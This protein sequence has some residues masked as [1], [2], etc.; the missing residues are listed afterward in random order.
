MKIYYEGHIIV[1]GTAGLKLFLERNWHVS[2]GE[3]NS[4]YLKS[5]NVLFHRM[6]LGLKSTDP[7]VD[8]IN[9]N[10]LDNRIKNLRL[11]T[12]QQ[13]MWNQRVNPER[14]RNGKPVTS[15]YKGVHFSYGA[16]RARISVNSKT[17]SLGSFK[18]E[19]L[20][21]LAY[22]EAALKYFG[23]YAKLNEV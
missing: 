4:L 6:L 8:H 12:N 21:A 19:K 16:Y 18:D 9:N 5:N 17:I 20:A 23:E 7:D 13:N 1:L 11:V 2:Y 10:G 15:K 3:S 14:T 22:N